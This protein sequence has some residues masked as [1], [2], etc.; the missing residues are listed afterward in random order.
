MNVRE[1]NVKR[2]VGERVKRKESR[3]RKRERSEMIER[4]KEC[5]IPAEE[6]LKFS[7]LLDGSKE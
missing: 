6:E 2:R 7:L 1:R 3:G 4:G 5:V